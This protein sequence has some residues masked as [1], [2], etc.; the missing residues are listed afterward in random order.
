MAANRKIE[1]EVK[2]KCFAENFYS[3]MTRDA[4]KLPRYAPQNIHNVQ[5]LSGEG[6]IRLG[7]VSVWDY[8][9][10]N[11]PSGVRTKTKTTAMDHQN[12]SVTFTVLDG[13]LS[14]DYTSFSNT[15]TITTPT[16]R[17]GNYNCLVKWSVQFQKANE[18]VADPTYFMK[19]HEDFTKEM[20]ANFLKEG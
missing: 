12:M 2:V 6:E 18:N 9:L 20:D 3:M 7:S 19:M 15:L 5:I 17:D 4:L 14:D 16:Q 1:V 13:Y 11:K 10:D 8:V